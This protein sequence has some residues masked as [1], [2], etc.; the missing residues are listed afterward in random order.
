MSHTAGYSITWKEDVGTSLARLE[1]Q[2]EKTFGVYEA[3]VARVEQLRQEQA[4]LAGEQKLLELTETALTTL[5]QQVSVESLAAIETTISYGLHT[6][7]DDHRLT[8]RFAVGQSRGQ[9][10]VE[11]LLVYQ[12]VE[13]PILDAFGG[14]PAQVVAF[15]LRLIVCH[16]LGLYPLILLD[17]SFSMVSVQYV[18][19]LARLLKELAEKLG[20]T[21]LLVT[22]QT[23]FV[24][25]AT[26]AYKIRETH[27]GVTFESV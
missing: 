10:S 25:H 6:V 26:H 16:R 27:E 3:K 24:E 5:L 9:Q 15:L 13:A 1:K 11:P 12:D 23:E 19:N 4:G 2:V 7:F 20:Y 8:F 22:H 14:G 17:E 18:P 21:F